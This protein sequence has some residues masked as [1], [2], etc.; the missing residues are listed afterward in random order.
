[1]N[2]RTEGAFGT[3]LPTAN[4]CPVQRERVLNSTVQCQTV[5]NRYFKIFLKSFTS[6]YQNHQK[7]ILK[8]I[9]LIFFKINIILKSIPNYKEKHQISIKKNQ[10]LVLTR[11]Q[12]PIIGLTSR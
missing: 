1:L 11:Y 4:T 12:T 2:W 7:K 10:I 5:P 8:N 3:V 9:N 6:A